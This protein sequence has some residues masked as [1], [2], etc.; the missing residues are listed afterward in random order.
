MV[1]H[2]SKRPIDIANDV[3]CKDVRRSKR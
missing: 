1:T 3:I 2:I